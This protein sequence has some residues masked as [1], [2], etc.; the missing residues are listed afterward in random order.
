MTTETK[1]QKR[2]RCARNGALYFGTLNLLYQ[3]SWYYRYGGT[4][5]HF[6]KDVTFGFI[7]WGIVGYAVG[8]T[9]HPV[10]NFLL[11]YVVGLA[12]LIA[13]VLAYPPVASVILDTN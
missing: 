13:L 9:K 12:V 6:L 4:A 2:W 10:R 11:V 8:G 5:T 1:A 3:A 7:L